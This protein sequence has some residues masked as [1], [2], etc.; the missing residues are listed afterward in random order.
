MYAHGRLCELHVQ[1]EFPCINWML[2]TIQINTVVTGSPNYASSEII[3]QF[4]YIY[5]ILYFLEYFC[6]YYYFQIAL[7]HGYNSRAGTIY[8]ACAID[9]MRVIIRLAR[10]IHLLIHE[11]KCSEYTMVKKRAVSR[12]IKKVTAH[13]LQQCCSPQALHRLQRSLSTSVSLA[14][15]VVRAW[16][17]YYSRA[18]FIS[19]NASEQTDVG[20]IR[21]REVFKEI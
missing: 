21:G 6:G 16:C 11:K 13:H 15:S 7:T 2:C 9:S 14:V 5:I 17:G 20:T 3:L 10:G 12:W 8:F 1:A 4:K 18:G 19:F